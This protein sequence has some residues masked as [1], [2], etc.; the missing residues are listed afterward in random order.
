M[1]RD[2]QR[3]QTTDWINVSVVLD[4]MT[5]DGAT[6]FCFAQTSAYEIIVVDNANSCLRL[7]NR[8]HGQVYNFAGDCEKKGRQDGINPLFT[9]PDSVQQDNQNPSLF[10]VIDFYGFEVRMVNKSDVPHVVTLINSR[11]RIYTYLTQDHDG[12]FLYITHHKGLELFN[13]LTN[14]SNDIIAESTNFADH[15]MIYDSCIGSFVAIIILQNNFVIIADY[16]R[17]MLYLLDLT[18][19]ST[20]TICTGVEGHRS[21]NSSF[22]Q[23]NQPWGLLEMDG[24]I[25]VGEYGSISVFK[26][27]LSFPNWALISAK[28][29]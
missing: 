20:S 5:I 12:R 16:S 8:L 3:L 18:T 4:L 14:T 11:G 23:V 24:D 2:H 6:I 17:N 7:F 15:A 1:F 28:K 19:N 9:H 21:G 10:Y 29:N 22:C 27:R 13:L 25:Y 26:G